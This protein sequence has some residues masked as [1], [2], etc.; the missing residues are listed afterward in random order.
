MLKDCSH[1]CVSKKHADELTRAIIEGFNFEEQV[2]PLL[3][4]CHNV[5]SNKDSMGRTA[6]QVAATYGRVKILSWLLSH[7][8]QPQIHAKDD[9]S[10]YSALH[11]AFFYGQLQAARIL[12]K[13]S[14]SLN[15]PIDYDGMSP[16]DHLT[17]DVS[18]FKS[19]DPLL[20]CEVYVWGSNSNYL[21]GNYLNGLHLI[22]WTMLNFV[23][24]LFRT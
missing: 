7:D 20:P 19:L 5:S 13:N 1:K 18:L 4:T 3:Q 21:L 24:I 17:Q 12:L 14:S 11:R 2:I 23:V 22:T 10:G 9:E 8:L 16:F 6:L 15:Q